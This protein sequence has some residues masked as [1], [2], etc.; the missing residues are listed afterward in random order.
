MIKAIKSFLRRLAGPIPADAVTWVVNDLGELGVR[1]E[2]TS[3]FMYK[4]G[5]IIYGSP[6]ND[7]TRMM[8]RPIQKSEFGEG[9]YT[10]TAM[11]TDSRGAQST[12][13][14]PLAVVVARPPLL[15]FGQWS[16]GVIAIIVP[17]I[18]LVLAFACAAWYAWHL[19]QR[20]RARVQRG[21]DEAENV[22]HSAVGLLKDDLETQI[23]ELEQQEMHRGLTP[24]EHATL[25]SLKR[26]L[27]TA[28][29]FIKEQ[30][31]KIKRIS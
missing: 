22:L 11:V 14:S 17:L 19:F 13:T 18:I 27:D 26:D 15:Q 20:F 2:G 4:G 23:T 24:E 5:S 30:M 31:E 9:T 3:Y 21:T 12:N 10:F 1:I 8:Q 7:G 29:R 6:H 28:E 16:L 25:A